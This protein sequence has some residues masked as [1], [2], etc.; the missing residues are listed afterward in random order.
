MKAEINQAKNRLRLTRREN[1]RA[2]LLAWLT[3][4]ISLLIL[5]SQVLQALGE[6][7]AEKVEP[8]EKEIVVIQERAEQGKEPVVSGKKRELNR[9]LYSLGSLG[10][11]LGPLTQQKPSKMSNPWKE[12]NGFSK[13]LSTEKGLLLVK[14]EIQGQGEEHNG[15]Q[16]R[17]REL[18][19]QVRGKKGEVQSWKRRAVFNGLITAHEHNLTALGWAPEEENDINPANDLWY[20]AKR[21]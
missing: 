19:E 3:S 21:N 1:R 17:K 10:R 20:M 12:S 9:E 18:R 6:Q 15:R 13:P 2:H 5:L 11:N 14:T 16:E 7:S 4:G 8:G